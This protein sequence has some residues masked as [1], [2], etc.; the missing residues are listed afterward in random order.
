M[1]GLRVGH[2]G[3]RR[4]V[5]RRGAHPAARHLHDGPDVLSNVL[6]LCPNDHVRFDF[7]AIWLDDDL[8]VVD[9]LRLETGHRLR[10]VAGHEID[11]DHV[12]YHRELWQDRYPAPRKPAGVVSS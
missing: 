5:R 3:A 6:C 4:V 9:G 1:P 12:R 11:L 8:C 2:L 10:T 7:G